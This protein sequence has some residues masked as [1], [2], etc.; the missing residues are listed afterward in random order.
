MAPCQTMIVQMYDIKY[1]TIRNVVIHPM[2]NVVPARLA[3]AG[4][5]KQNGPGITPGAVPLT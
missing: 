5:V 1:D 4:E 2:R 3:R